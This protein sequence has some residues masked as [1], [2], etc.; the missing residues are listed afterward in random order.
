MSTPTQV[1][2][3]TL[4][5]K[6]SKS[7]SLLTGM[8]D[9]MEVAIL[10][11]SSGSIGG[12]ATFAGGLKTGT[13]ELSDAVNSIS[14]N[15][16]PS[17][18]PGLNQE[19]DYRVMWRAGITGRTET[20][21]FVMP[22]E[23][24]D[25]D[26]LVAG[27]GNI[28]NGVAYL[29]Q[30]DLGVPG[31]V[32][33]LND[34]GHVID[35]LG[36]PVP[37]TDDLS[38]LEASIA[39]EAIDRNQAISQLRT[40]L[41]AEL[42][43][44]IDAT[45]A[46][47]HSYTDTHSATLHG[48]VQAEAAVRASGDLQVQSNLD[49]T[50]AALQDELD[51]LAASTGG[52]TDALD[53]KADLDDTGHVPVAQIPGEIYTNVYPVPDEAAM[54]ALDPAIVNR[55]DLAVRPDG[56]FLLSTNDPSHLEDWVPLSIISTVNGKRG[57]VVLTASDVGAIAVG[58]SVAMDQVTGLDTA[59]LGKAS[60]A[61]FQALQTSVTNAQSIL[62]TPAIVTFLTTGMLPD[63][64]MPAD[65]ALVNA[66]HQVTDKQGNVVAAGGGGTGAVASVN[67][68]VG[69]VILNLSDIS[70][71]GG[72][73]LQTQV[74]GLSTTLAGKASTTDTRFS[75]ARTPLAHAASH[76]SGQSDAITVAQS[77]VTG[78]SPIL[79]NNALSNSSNAVGRI[80]SLEGRVTILEGGGGGEGGG[81]S[82][83]AVFYDSSNTT[84]P[85]TSFSSV[86]LHS[87]WGIDSDGTL[88]GVAS[89]PYYLHSGVRSADV[90]YPY[91]TPNGHLQ[92]RQWNEAGPADA[93][94]ALASDLTTTNATMA[95]KASSADLS[96]LSTRVDGKASSADLSALA[97][98]VGTKAPQSSLDTTN[99]TVAT[100]ANQSDLNTLSNTV[101]TKADATTVATHTSQITTINNTL[102]T[103]ADLVTGR[104]PNS[105]TS[106]TIP[107][108][109]IA[110]LS[111]YLA[112]LNSTTGV[113][114]AAYLSNLGAVPS[115]S[116]AIGSVNGLQ[117]ALDA[118]APLVNGLI[119]TS[120]MPALSLG[121]SVPV[122]NR[123]AL[124]AL[125]STQVQPGDLG[126]ITTGS[127]KGTYM[128]MGTDPS[129]WANWQ[130][131]STPD[132][133]V[134]SI[135][136]QTGAVALSYTDVGAMAA[137]ASMPI[138]QV[139]GLQ[140]SLDS[141]ATT[142]ALVSGL[143]G[144]MSPS[145]VQ[146]MFYTSSMVKRADYVATS[147]VASLAG[148][149]SADGVLMPLGAIVL[150][151]NQASSVLNGLW[152]VSSSSWTRPADFATGS[153]LAR[154]SIVIVSN[155]T[156]SGNG[157]NNNA[158][159]WQMTTTSGFIDTSLNSW[160]RIGWSAPPL[161]PISGN[162]INVT[163]TYPNLTFAAKTV[164]GGGILSTSDGLS[165]DTNLV[166]KKVTG[167]IPSGSTVVGITHN[168]NT[169]APIVQLYEIASGNMVLAGV[170]VT[171]SNA[172]SIEF[173]S[174]PATN[175]FRFVI[176]G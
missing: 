106:T 41:E 115:N 176:A 52:N 151:T 19:I 147:A 132:A 83:T 45:L 20:F 2:A 82:T 85:L 119:P 139:S 14:F 56:I 74:S 39:V 126:I 102:P 156:A 16:I 32:A 44:Q 110:G 33:R 109:Y 111:P 150:L 104:V 63:S 37:T 70:A 11:L 163:G 127:D 103:K 90:A 4:T 29:Q 157:Q 36:I 50:R 78:L 67:N 61:D 48:E 12:Q 80:Y 172:I 155:A 6:F 7:V 91:I 122:A 51:S 65:I 69:V 3:R 40:N 8:P 54:L 175:Q 173:N 149:Q 84:D 47:A 58:G 49:A 94:Y 24:L 77:Q 124:V 43:G 143:A 113:F 118:K 140:T 145:D 137:N 95:T 135:N 164:S 159:I 53:H 73:I 134:T 60:T 81:A 18:S 154:D 141:K 68:K 121:T 160:T 79:S 9:V 26:E 1:I 99:A 100:K 120:V 97:I 152:T 161:S 27:P 88:T 93:T 136:G 162:G 171:S 101:A 96:T 148:Q 5:F 142:S 174:A 71:Q 55:A 123:A 133:P 38:S 28:I 170:T 66:A 25:W 129:V 167:T 17:F 130:L 57:T 146:G 10:P 125:T 22:D 35:S 76:G 72:S 23:D 114:D 158:T 144:K 117:G 168:L 31:R 92:L 169:L 112:H 138:S 42:Y 64:A 21:D 107:V 116:L 86:F 34:A 98:T 108:G 131:L 128:L 30:S 62:S 87:P 166:I 75:D 59:L 13:V 165:M 89:T 153:W 46:T 105:Q 15:L